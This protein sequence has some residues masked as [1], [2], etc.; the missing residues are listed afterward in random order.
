MC[1]IGRHLV[2][3]NINIEG[4]LV[5]NPKVQQYLPESILNLGVDF[6]QRIQSL[7]DLEDNW[8]EKGITK[9]GLKE[10]NEIKSL[11]T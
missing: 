7:H 9:E 3:Y 11:Y 2:N 1:A 4:M 6:L 10:V 8:D 5:R